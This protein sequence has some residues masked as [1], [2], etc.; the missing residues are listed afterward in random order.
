MAYLNAVK[1]EQ[2][3]GSE[4]KTVTL[5]LRDREMTFAGLDLLLNRSMPNFYFHTTTAYEYAP[6]WHRDRQARFHGGK[7][8]AAGCER[9]EQETLTGM[10]SWMDQ[11]FIAADQVSSPTAHPQRPLQDTRS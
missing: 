4:E 1:P 8:I 5:K 6:Q 3:D 2:V 10:A 11:S 9:S 7:L